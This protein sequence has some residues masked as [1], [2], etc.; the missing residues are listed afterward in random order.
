VEKS[1]QEDDAVRKKVMHLNTLQLRSLC[2]ALVSRHELKGDFELM[3]ELVEQFNESVLTGG[4]NK[5][6]KLRPLMLAILDVYHRAA[7]D[8]AIVCA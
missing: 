1:L 8:V 6:C 4:R 5:V 7:A 2:D 3:A